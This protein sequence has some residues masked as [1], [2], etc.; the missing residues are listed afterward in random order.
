MGFILSLLL[1]LIFAALAVTRPRMAAYFLLGAF[2][3]F[4]EVGPGSTSFTASFVFNQGFVGFAN[5]RL[6]EI[7]TASV[8]APVVMFAAKDA[9]ST[10]SVFGGEKMLFFLFAA[11]IAGFTVLEY[12]LEGTYNVSYWRFILTGAMQFQVLVVLFRTEEDVVQ[13]VK[14]AIVMLALKA[15]WGLAMWAAGFGVMSPRGRL[16]FFWD[17]RQVEAFAF[18]AVMLVAYL[19]NFSSLP[20]K[21]RVLPFGWACVMLVFLA[22]AVLGSIRRTIWVTTMLATLMV[23][24]SSKRT[25]ALHYFTIVFVVSTVV[26]AMLLLPGLEK[27]RDHMGQYVASLNLFDDQQRTRN[28]DNDVHVQ[29]VESYAKMIIENPDILLFGT[30]GPS[31]LHYQDVLRG[32][33]GGEY[34]LGMAHNGPLRSTLFFG[35]VGLLIYL[36]YYFLSIVRGW[37]VLQRAPHDHVLTHFALACAALLF[38]EFAASMFFVPP[39]W[40]QSKGLFYTFFKSFVVGMTALHLVRAR[41]A[42]RAPVAT[43]AVPRSSGVAP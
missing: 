26:G 40:T 19:L 24:L 15:A 20:A 6:I 43:S 27:F 10:P 37:R 42:A 5:V 39:F 16:P 35:V 4:E 3:F 28:I 14:V 23:M 34:Q 30:Y 11:L 1:S 33:Y 32:R 8:W 18:A 2:V 41:A 22:G 17:S 21:W 9:I 31:G 13:L 36:W 12:A 25:T 29:N 7:L 38:L